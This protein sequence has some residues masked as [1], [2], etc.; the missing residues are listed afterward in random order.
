VTEINNALLGTEIEA[1]DMVETIQAAA[2]RFGTDGAIIGTNA[3]FRDLFFQSN[4]S[5]KPGSAFGDLVRDTLVNG[6]FEWENTV[7]VESLSAEELTELTDARSLEIRHRDGRWFQCIRCD[8]SNGDW[9][10]VL[11]DVTT[12]RERELQHRHA[13]KMHS[14]GQ[15]TGGIAHDLNNLMTIIQGNLELIE[16][17]A[18]TDDRVVDW[19]GS[20]LRATARGADLTQRLLTFAGRRPFRAEN[21]DATQAIAGVVARV[22]DSLGSNIDIAVKNDGGAP[23]ISADPTQFE[24]ALMNLLLNARDS[25]PDGGEINVSV[26]R[27]RA[28]N[29]PAILDREPPENGFVVVSVADSGCGMSREVADRAFDPF[30]TTKPKGAGS[31]LGL[32][33]VYGFVRQS[34]GEITLD[35]S[36]QRGT[37]V[38][39][40]LPASE[41]VSRQKRAGAEIQRAKSDE[42][43]LVVEDDEEVRRIAAEILGDLGYRVVQA[44]TGRHAVD[45]LNDGLKPTLV[46]SDIVMPGGVDGEQLAEIVKTTYPGLPVLLASGY[47]ESANSA[48]VHGFKVLAK[49]YSRRDLAAEIRN[50]I[51]VGRCA[52]A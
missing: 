37:S 39:L 13:E 23:S 49:P 21:V 17:F 25:M 22:G 14:I 38:A 41:Q 16:E 10:W 30:F 8:L 29:W 52:D 36:P 6:D 50:T 44:E 32:S 20:A 3:A 2:A 28:E 4:C 31:G 26:N 33:M 35:T 19:V 1:A 40:F 12:I 47:R 43:V 46:F 24:A 42:T 48:E 51:D 45:I 9:L 34:G 7:A 27:G 18:A 5:V 11:H 15:L